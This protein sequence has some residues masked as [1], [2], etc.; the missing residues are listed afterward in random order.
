MVLDHCEWHG[1]M[2]LD[3]CEWHG[4]MVLDHCGELTDDAKTNSGHS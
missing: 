1:L 2:V 4:L 3:H